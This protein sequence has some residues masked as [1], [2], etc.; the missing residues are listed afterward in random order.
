[1]NKKRFGYARWVVMV[2]IA[3]FIVAL[4]ARAADEPKEAKPDKK[5]PAEKADPALTQALNDAIAALS[6]EYQTAIRNRKPLRI[7][8]NYFQST[9]GQPTLPPEIILDA[10][11]KSKLD[12]IEKSKKGDP[13]LHGFVKWQ[14]MSGLPTVLEAGLDK[15]LVSAYEKVPVLSPRYGMSD[16]DRKNLDKLVSGGK[17]EHQRD[18]TLQYN[19]AADLSEV[20]NTQVLKY[21]DALAARAPRTAGGVKAMVKDAYERFHAGLVFTEFRESLTG[22]LRTWAIEAK[23]GEVADMARVLRKILAEPPVTYYSEP[24]FDS[25]KNTYSWRLASVT[26]DNSKS[27]EDITTFLEDTA[28]EEK[29]K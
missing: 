18:I 27:L 9:P 12:A 11:E 5:A 15:K 24:V 6:L 8:S 10:I 29:S 7:A 4:P 26:F 14:L 16:R 19:K 20:A 28:A 21:R 1:M 17:A 23:P 25:K 2:A 22:A 13:G 3:A